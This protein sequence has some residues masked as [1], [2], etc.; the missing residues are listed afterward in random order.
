MLCDKKWRFLEDNDKLNYL[1]KHFST[2]VYKI[3]S[4]STNNK[5]N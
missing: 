3:K 4:L 5:L 1:I 2:C